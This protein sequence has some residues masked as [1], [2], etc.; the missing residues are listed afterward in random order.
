MRASIV[1]S[2]FLALA[3]A[4]LAAFNLFLEVQVQTVQGQIAADVIQAPAT[5]DVVDD[6]TVDDVA[7][8]S[9]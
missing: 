3:I 1:P 2:L 7:E 9:V 5:V 4:A 6:A 8:P